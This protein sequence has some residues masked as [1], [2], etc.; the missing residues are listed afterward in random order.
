M[1]ANKC[2]A[3]L[4]C[5]ATLKPLKSRIRP[6]NAICNGVAKLVEEMLSRMATSLK[7]FHFGN[8]CNVSFFVHA[9]A[10]K[11]KT[12][13]A[14]FRNGV[15]THGKPSCYKLRLLQSPQ[16]FPWCAL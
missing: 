1:W 8:T 14:R 2:I 6:E 13:V 5:L 11:W 15:P 7:L 3:T 10:A 16:L 4:T 12:T 9:V